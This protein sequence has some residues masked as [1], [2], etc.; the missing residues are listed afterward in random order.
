[1][2]SSA[3]NGTSH[4][5]W[6]PYFWSLIEDLNGI[7]AVVEYGRLIS[8]GTSKKPV[9]TYGIHVCASYFFTSRPSRPPCGQKDKS[10]LG[11]LGSIL[12]TSVAKGT[13]GPMWD[14]IWDAYFWELM[15][16]LNGLYGVVEYGMLIFISFGT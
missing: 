1:M 15:W 9:V 2:R 3:V 8:F 6:D 4:Q 13:S 16:H 14:P 7:C 10:Q 11:R 12:Q 5:F